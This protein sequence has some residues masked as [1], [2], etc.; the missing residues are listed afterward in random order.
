[1]RWFRYRRKGNG[2]KNRQKL[3]Q[4]NVVKNGEKPRKKPPIVPSRNRFRKGGKRRKKP[5][6]KRDKIEQKTTKNFLEN[7][8]KFPG[9]KTAKNPAFGS[10]K[11]KTKSPEKRRL[12][13]G[14]NPSERKLKIRDKTYYNRL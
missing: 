7:Q 11:T 4:K 5:G 3:P 1:M 13:D 2:N 6:A 10:P 12:S 9:A 14:K 8:R